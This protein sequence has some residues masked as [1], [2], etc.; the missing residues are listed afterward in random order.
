MSITPTCIRWMA[1]DTVVRSQP[2]PSGSWVYYRRA[3]NGFGIRPV[4]D[5][6]FDGKR[7][8]V[9]QPDYSS[10]AGSRSRR[11]RLRILQVASYAASLR[12]QC[13]NLESITT[14]A[15]GG[16]TTGVVDTNPN[17][18]NKGNGMTCSSGAS[19]DPSCG[20]AAY[21]EPEFITDEFDLTPY[22]G[23]DFLIRWA[24]STDPGL[25]FR[26]W[27]IDDIELLK[28]G[29]TRI[30][31][32]ESRIRPEHDDNP[33]LQGWLEATGRHRRNMLLDRRPW[34]GRALMRTAPGPLA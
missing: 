8:R 28:N 2:H 31:F 21:P 11:L 12:V 30:F 6:A 20:V 34:T 29:A 5:I 18:T 24:Y 23:Q 32:D 26:G 15:E 25:A 7:G 3:G 22:I 16:P 10:R 1:Q 27:V 19:D 13:D 9:D 17:G 14:P 4:L 33:R